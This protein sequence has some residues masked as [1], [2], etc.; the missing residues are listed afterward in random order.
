VTAEQPRPK[1]PNANATGRLRSASRD[2]LKG[3]ILERLDGVAVEHPSG[4]QAVYAARYM[5]QRPDG[6]GIELMFEKSARTPANL[7][8]C[9]RYVLPLLDGE[10]P[11]TRAPAALLHLPNDQE[12]EPRYGR[13]SALK[14]MCV[15]ACKFD[16]L[17]GVIGIQF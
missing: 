11:H 7:W 9:E 1:L 13:H 17:G 16:P 10:I 15:S 3:A 4:H 2:S 5:L 14:P 12:E 6:Q 8:V